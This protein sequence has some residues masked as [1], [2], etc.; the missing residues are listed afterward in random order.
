MLA[1]W[2]LVHAAQ[3]G[4]SGAFGQLYDRYVDMVFRFVLFRVHDRTM[5][6]DLT[7]ETFLRA[8]R[9][10]TTVSYQGKDVGAWFGD[11]R[12]QPGARSRQVQP[13]PAGGHHR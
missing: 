10:I 3:Q 12:A 8:L 1:T 2:A 4:D 9:R 6:E 13:A 5:A 11:H 7:S